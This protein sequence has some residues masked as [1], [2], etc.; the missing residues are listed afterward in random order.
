MINPSILNLVPTLADDW[1]V[2]HEAG[3]W[4]LTKSGSMPCFD[5][6]HS[7]KLMLDHCDGVNDI[8]TITRSLAK[9]HAADL[10][11]VKRDITSTLQRLAASG[12][13][14]LHPISPKRQNPF[15]FFD[16]IYC[17]NLDQAENKWQTAME[18]FRLLGID[19]RVQ[20]FS[21][22]ETPNN[23]HIGCALSHRNIVQA[24]NAQ[25]LN[26]VLV[27]EDDVV[28]DTQTLT[29]FSKSLEQTKKLNWDILYLGG[30][31]WGNI[32]PLVKNCD[33][34]REV[35]DKTFGPTSTHALAYS[36]SIFGKLLKQFPDTPAAMAK[37]LKEVRPGI[38]QVFA[39]D[40]SLKRLIVE[41]RVASQPPLLPQESENFIPLV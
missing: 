12:V 5:I 38:D 16:A 17:I 15:Y 24:A 29:H 30:H 28:F 21:A 35:T 18:Q 34:V 37:Y 9:K 7:T 4:R 14:L 6:N 26:N 32:Y 23:Y 2:A 31:C 22:V 19:Q 1:R 39:V 13:V 11:V 27:F 8:D 10:D 33:C 36:S 40:A 20:R 41:P 25:G 3:F